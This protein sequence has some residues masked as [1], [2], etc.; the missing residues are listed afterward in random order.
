MGVLFAY[1][2]TERGIRERGIVC[3]PS[4]TVSEVVRRP[5][6]A[7]APPKPAPVTAI[8]R[9]RSQEILVAV[10]RKHHLTVRD[11]VGR[12]RFPHH[13]AARLDAMQQIK[14][15]WPKATNVQIG[16]IFNRNATTIMDLLGK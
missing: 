2:A 10:A 5:V 1:S 11:L 8:P 16:L 15:A 13:V 9:T 14:K 12:R 6:R 7:P 4:E 3:F